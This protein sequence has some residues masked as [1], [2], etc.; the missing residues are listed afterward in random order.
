MS[1][2]IT[3]AA[4]AT[5]ALSSAASADVVSLNPVADAFVDSA[6][7]N[8][9]YGGG[10]GLAVAAP[11]LP[12]GEFQSVLRFDASAAVASFNASFGAGNWTIQSITLTCTAAAPNHPIFNAQAAG[13]LSASWMQNDSWVEGTGTP[14]A[15]GATGITFATLPSFL[16]GAD[17]ALGTYSFAGGTSGAN[18]YAL[19]LTS[20]FS[21]DVTTGGL[22][23]LR[24]A[25]VGST[26]GYV[27][28]SRSFGTASARPVLAI[29]AVPAPGVAILLAIAAARGARRPAP[30]IPS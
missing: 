22:V 3:C 27:F 24:I 23:S 15:P 8:N 14:Q 30:T 4:M 2:R 11:G 26:I 9:N 19:A 20:A 12:Q 16:S 21:A 1:I 13:Q 5:L 17:E 18:I 10:G 7:A 28:N 6:L 25:P 29:T